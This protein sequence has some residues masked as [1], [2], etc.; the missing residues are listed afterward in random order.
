MP[1]YHYMKKK[2]VNMEWRKILSTEENRITILED[3]DDI[4]CSVD[5]TV[6]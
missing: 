3:G 5:V 6:D 1:F 2:E 4:A